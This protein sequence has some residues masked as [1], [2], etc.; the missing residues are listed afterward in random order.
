MAEE[1]ELATEPCTGAI[2][3]RIGMFRSVGIMPGICT[4][5]FIYMY[6]HRKRE[7]KNI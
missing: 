4:L 5:I 6:I 2:V 7:Q 1:R 3:V